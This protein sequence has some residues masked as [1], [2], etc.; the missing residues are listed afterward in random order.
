[1]FNVVLQ[2]MDYFTP[3][4]V[5]GSGN[6]KMKTKSLLSSASHRQALKKSQHSRY[7]VGVILIPAKM[8]TF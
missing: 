5:L 2:L 3:G 8:R 4:T 7:R 6:S 1:M